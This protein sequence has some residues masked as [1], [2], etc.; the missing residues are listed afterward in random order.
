MGTG[1][2]KVLWTS[3]CGLYKNRLSRHPKSSAIWFSRFLKSTEWK[4]GKKD[5]SK[6]HVVSLLVFLLVG[7]CLCSV[8]ACMGVIFP[9][10]YKHGLS[11]RLYSKLAGALLGCLQIQATQASVLTCALFS[12]N[13]LAVILWGNCSQHKE[14]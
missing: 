7:K 1:L 9:R 5:W 2:H 14:F 8:Y 10:W 4:K 13:F 12:Y 3:L 6:R 11:Q